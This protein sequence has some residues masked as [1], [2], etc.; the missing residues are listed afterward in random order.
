MG[1]KK[2]DLLVSVVNDG[3]Q[4]ESLKDSVEWSWTLLEDLHDGDGDLLE[5]L[6]LVELPALQVVA[7]PLPVLSD[8][9]L[10]FLGLGVELLPV[11]ASG[12]D[13]PVL[14]EVECKFLTLPHPD[15]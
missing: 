6:A 2:R 11:V 13:G 8:Q 5:D 4:E 3:A 15:T 1:H 7:L 9:R 14:T 10:G 12:I